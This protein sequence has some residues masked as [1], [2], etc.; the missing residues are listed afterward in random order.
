ML[1]VG[2]RKIRKKTK[3]KILAAIIMYSNEG[4]SEL[5]SSLFDV[6]FNALLKNMCFLSF[7]EFDVN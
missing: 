7:I 4:E 6:D 3:I 2:L 5:K 1:V